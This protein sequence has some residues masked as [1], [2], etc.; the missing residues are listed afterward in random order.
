[1]EETVQKPI[2]TKPHFY[3][4]CLPE[5]QRIAKGCG[6]NLIV[7]G[8][9]DRDFDLVAIPWVCTPDCHYE[10]ITQLDKFINGEVRWADRSYFERG[11][12]FSRLPGGRY[13]Y[14]INIY[15]GGYYYGKTDEGERLYT[16]D[17]EYYIDISITPLVNIPVNESQGK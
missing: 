9:M 4:V 10:L 17:P 13:S 16:P 2:K 6:Y 8:S 15:R 3:A 1:M 12:M 7:H 5:M 11:Y 14:V